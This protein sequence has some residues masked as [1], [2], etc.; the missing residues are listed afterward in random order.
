MNWLWV[1]GLMMTITAVIHSVA[2]EKMLI[3]PIL[4]K[5]QSAIPTARGRKVLRSAWHLTSAFMLT[6]ALVV[7]WPHSD[8]GLLTVIGG[9]WLVVGLFSLIS[10]RGQHVGWPTLTGSGLTALI[11]IWH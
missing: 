10:S 2:G 11:G 5:G 7:I 9:F 4:A 8:A 1:S 3:G 6:N